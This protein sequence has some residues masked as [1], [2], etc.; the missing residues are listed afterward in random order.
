MY[1]PPNRG[2]KTWGNFA[3]MPGGNDPG[4]VTAPTVLANAFLMPRGYTLV[5]S[6]WDKAAGTI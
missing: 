6:G 5:W 4:S 1:E 3:R 2:S